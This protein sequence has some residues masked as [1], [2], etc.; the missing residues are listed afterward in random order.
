MLPT[1]AFNQLFGDL[2]RRQVEYSYGAEEDTY[3]SMIALDRSQ[4]DRLA[5][6]AEVL[7]FAA[8]WAWSVTRFATAIVAD[9]LLFRV[10]W[11]MSVPSAVTLYC[12]FPTE[13]DSR[14]F[15]NAMREA[16]PFSWNGPEPGEVARALGLVGPRGIAL[17]ATAKGS[18][19]TAVYFKSEAHSGEAWAERLAALL[20]A[21]QY[22]AQ[23]QSVI[24]RD[25]KALYLPGPAG[26]IGLDDGGGGIPAT[27]KF[28]PANVPLE[29]ALGFLGDKQVASARIAALR[30]IALGLR[31]ES[32]SY[33]GV[34]YNR[35]SFAGWRLYFACEP[36]CCAPGAQA[37]VRFQRNLR[38]VR[39]LPHY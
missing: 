31:A 6:W 9:A 18:T 22:P 17:R 4:L 14:G 39:R 36:G 25:L 19:R 5:R 23:L 20:A 7:R 28:D 16:R 34:Q 12:R 13:P 27:L 15:A 24:E 1:L 3:T 37:D 29:A 11:R 38:P 26:V 35:Q 2:L 21:C 32:A 30:A 10:D 8:D 33:V